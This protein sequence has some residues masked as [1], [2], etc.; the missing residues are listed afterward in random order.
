MADTYA[1]H[2][3]TADEC[4]ELVERTVVGRIAM[5]LEGR[6]HIF[7]INFVRDRDSIVFRTA[8][9]TKLSATRHRHVAFEIDGYEPEQST[10]WS[11]IIAGWAAEIES[12][13]EWSGVDHLALFPWHVAPKAHFVRVAAD[14][15][16]GRRFLAPYAGASG[17][18]R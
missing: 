9:G 11:V 8:V 15:I 18:Q 3:L 13:V 16:S 4:W 5:C 12:N 7:P 10:A 2:E 1:T 6:A 17:F 14:E